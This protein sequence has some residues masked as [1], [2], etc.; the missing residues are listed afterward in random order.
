[1]ETLI[2]NQYKKL[3]SLYIPCE[4]GIFAYHLAT[5]TLILVKS[6]EEYKGDYHFNCLV[7]QNEDNQINFCNATYCNK[8]LSITDF[9]L[10]E[11]IS[12]H[13]EFT[14]VQLELF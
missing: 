12:K 10:E 11:F 13:N 5:G 7:Y 14:G 1:M 2:Y 6:M 8:E 3:F 4:K 9:S